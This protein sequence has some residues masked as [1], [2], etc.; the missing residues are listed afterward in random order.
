[1]EINTSKKET[2]RNRAYKQKFFHKQKSQNL[3]NG[4]LKYFLRYGSVI[5]KWRGKKESSIKCYLEF[6]S[7]FQF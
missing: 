1:M 3:F 2:C 4:N 6:S 7:A 5:I